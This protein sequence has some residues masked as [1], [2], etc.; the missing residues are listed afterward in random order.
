MINNN[1]KCRNM[2]CFLCS[3]IEFH[4]HVEKRYKPTVTLQDMAEEHV[5]MS[6]DIRKPSVADCQ[7]QQRENIRKTSVADGQQQQQQREIDVRWERKKKC[8]IFLS[9]FCE[10]WI[11]GKKISLMMQLLL[12]QCCEQQ[13]W[14]KWCSTKVCTV[15]TTQGHLNRAKVRWWLS[16]KVRSW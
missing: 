12:F 13:L 5:A 16:S 15:T 6:S 9:A 4:T 11:R 1:N 14:D 8:H 2:K 10:G 3:H 7:Q